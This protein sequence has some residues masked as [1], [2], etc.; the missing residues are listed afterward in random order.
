M[1]SMF[2][3][4][5]HNGKYKGYISEYQLLKEIKANNVILERLHL[6]EDFIVNLV[7]YI[8]STYLGDE[9]INKP[10]DIEGHFNWGFDKVVS[11]FEEEDINFRDNQELK[12]YFFD[13]FLK[14][15]YHSGKEI[16]TKTMI[17]HWNKLFMLSTNK[18]T[19]E[20]K[21]L[22]TLYQIFDNSFNKKV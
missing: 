12:S 2:Y 7:Q 14:E 4:N 11:E 8:Q 13:Y 16:S 6:Y 17:K 1:K 3:E 20:F 18:D 10:E 22:L 21:T 5:I 9:Y 19:I 15:F